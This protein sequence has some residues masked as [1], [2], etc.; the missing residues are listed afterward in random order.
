MENKCIIKRVKVGSYW[1]FE[2]L[3]PKYVK[4]HTRNICIP[5]T[6]ILLRKKLLLTL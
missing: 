5:K 2:G 1:K 4:P 6:R 3:I